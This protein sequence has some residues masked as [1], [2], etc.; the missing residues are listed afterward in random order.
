MCKKENA[1]GDCPVHL[2][3]HVSKTTDHISTKFGIARSTLKVV[4]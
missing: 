4:R 1:Y 3:V 2:P